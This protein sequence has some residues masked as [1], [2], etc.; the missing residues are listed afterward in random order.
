MLSNYDLEDICKI[1]KLPIVGVYSKERLPSINYIG[2]YY[3]NM[4]NYDDG[5]G[6]HWIFARIFPN[7]EAIYFD[8]YG[9][10]SPKEVENFLS[11]FRPYATNNRQIQ[12]LESENCGLYCV[13]CD[14][15]FTYD[16][17]Y[18]KPIDENFDDFLNM[19]SKFPEKNDKVLKEY[20]RKHN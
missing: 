3:I 10:K 2:S 1:L 17:I 6:T 18:K 14:Y 5:D 9:L 15:F 20:L 11:T 8:S 7:G 13:A 4:Q 16:F 12:S 19:W